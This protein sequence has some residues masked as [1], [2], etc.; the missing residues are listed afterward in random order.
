MDILQSLSDS[1]MFSWVI[2]PIL[3][4]VFRIIDVSMGTIRIIFVSKG[5]KLLAPLLGF[6]EISIWLLAISQIMQNLDNVVCFFAYAG[7][8][9][10]GNYIG[11]ILE[12]KLALGTLIIR[13][14]LP[15]DDMEIGNKLYDEGF[16]VTTIDAHGKNG[17]VIVIYT[18][19]KRKDLARAIEIIEN[20]NSN[21]FYSVEDIK[22][23][24]HGIFP[25]GGKP[26]GSK[27]VGSKPIQSRHHQ[28]RKMYSKSVK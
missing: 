14:F 27:P 17:D 20:C 21:A 12:E 11:V 16:G 28:K 1:Q 7:G 26:V 2:L 23:V 15:K 22:V 3:I 5:K 8:F 25:K 6:F 9:A 13:I 24:N 19:I 10:M 18:V 4:F